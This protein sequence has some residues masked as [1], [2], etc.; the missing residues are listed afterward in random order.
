MEQ[1]E[2]RKV[3]GQI[4]DIYFA[5]KSLL[6]YTEY[7]WIAVIEAG[8]GK[9]YNYLVTSSDKIDGMDTLDKQIETHFDE[10]NVKSNRFD[11]DCYHLCAKATILNCEVKHLNRCLGK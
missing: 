10:R 2:S 9:F 11:W 6:G 8:H 3:N 7:V 4:V 1:M 5:Q